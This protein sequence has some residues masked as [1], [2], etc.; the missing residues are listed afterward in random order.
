M[1]SGLRQNAPPEKYAAA[2][3]LV[4]AGTFGVLTGQRR[5]FHAA[6]ISASRSAVST[7]RLRA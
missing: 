5:A 3:T 7:N 6:R 2:T 1:R 4:E